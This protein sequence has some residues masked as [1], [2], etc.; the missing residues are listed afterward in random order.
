MIPTNT[1]LRPT[2]DVGGV[3]GGNTDTIELDP[4]IVYLIIG[5][6]ALLG[7]FVFMLIAAVACLYYRIR[8]SRSHVDDESQ[9]KYLKKSAHT[10]SSAQL[11]AVTESSFESPTSRNRFS[12]DS[13]VY[14]SSSSLGQADGNTTRS[15]SPNDE[16]PPAINGERGGE[17][18]AITNKILLKPVENSSSPSHS[19][20]AGSND[21]LLQQTTV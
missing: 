2:G 15:N 18:P 20:L 17:A 8:G 6:V 7:L 11:L 1:P 12:Q 4:Y 10:P 14:I 16:N 3:Q 5:L 21:N 9:L 19:S 13:A